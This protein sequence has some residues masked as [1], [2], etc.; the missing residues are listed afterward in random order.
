[1]GHSALFCHVGHLL[2]LICCAELIVGHIEVKYCAHFPVFWDLIFTFIYTHNLDP[3]NS[4]KV[5]LA[6]IKK[7]IYVIP[8]PPCQ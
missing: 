8:P 5:L 2:E 7:H 6:L 3:K 1:M 4:L